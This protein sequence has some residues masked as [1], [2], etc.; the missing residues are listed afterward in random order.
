ML[1][2]TEVP[3][4]W[5]VDYRGC[6]STDAR[7]CTEARGGV[8]NLT[9]S[10]SWLDKKIDTLGA[11]ANLEYT[12]NS[13]VGQFGFDTLGVAVSGRGNV[14][15]D[16]QLV[17]TVATKDFFLGNLGLAN[18]Q[19]DFGDGTHPTGFLSQL[20]ASNLIPSLSYGY[21]AGASYRKRP[22]EKL[23]RAHADQ[24]E[25]KQTRA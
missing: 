6:T 19:H 17:A 20:N 5:I 12:V 8:Y 10:K 25:I 9:A 3:E 13:D 2:S 1:A 18:R 11:E 16:D 14:S 21:T 22:G 7:N 15:L 4:T 23:D 24:M